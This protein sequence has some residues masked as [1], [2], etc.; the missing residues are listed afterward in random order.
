MSVLIVVGK[1][2]TCSLCRTSGLVAE[3]HPYAFC[4]MAKAVG[5]ESARAN[6]NAVLDHGRALER[7]GL[8]N[9]A[10]ISAVREIDPR[11]LI[12]SN[13]H[14]A[15]WGPDNA[16][17]YTDIRQAGRYSR[18]DAI[19]TCAFARDGY[20]YK[21]RPTEVPIREDRALNANGRAVRDLLLPKDRAECR[22]MDLARKAKRAA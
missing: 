21:R 10:P 22:A 6:L 16:G 9:S 5:R 20:T 7:L 11:Y 2:A 13:E 4:V 18:E 3:Y 17:Y 15:W 19:K 8:P 14:G 1:E 12:W